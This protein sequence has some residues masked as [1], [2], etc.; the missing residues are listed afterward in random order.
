MSDIHIFFFTV[1]EGYSPASR[2]SA[3]LSMS[4]SPRERHMKN[5]S[6]KSLSS[7]ISSGVESLESIPDSEK[8]PDPDKNAH[9][10]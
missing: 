1:A 10:V 6:N 7:E 5:L 8:Q 9:P 4:A 3:F 2:S